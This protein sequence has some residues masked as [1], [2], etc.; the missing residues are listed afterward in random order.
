VAG[1]LHTEISVRHRELNPDTVA[2]LITKYSVLH[3]KRYFA[4]LG[5]QFADPEVI[6]EKLEPGIWFVL[7]N[8]SLITRSSFSNCDL[9]YFDVSICRVI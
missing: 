3:Y 9:T 8:I 2:H 7:I 5:F 4:V 6:M 1:W